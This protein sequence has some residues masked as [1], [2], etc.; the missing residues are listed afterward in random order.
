MRAKIALLALVVLTLMVADGCKRVYFHLTEQAPEKTTL[1][2][3]TT[4]SYYELN[5]SI[6]LT[7]GRYQIRPGDSIVL[8]VEGQAKVPKTNR[9]SIAQL[10]LTEVARLYLTLPIPPKPGRYDTRFAAIC[11]IINS[12]KYTIGDNLFVCQSGEVVVDSFKNGVYYGQF[13]GDYLNTTNKQVSAAG[14]LKAGQK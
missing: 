4:K 9:E 6:A 8:F 3:T 5:R 2:F 11:E 13:S 7:G 1:R 12:R 10:E 14:T